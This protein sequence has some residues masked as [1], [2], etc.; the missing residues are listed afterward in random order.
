MAFY[1]I[2][3]QYEL[4]EPGYIP[5]LAPGNGPERHTGEP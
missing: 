5:Q 3:A 4:L 2:S 1:A